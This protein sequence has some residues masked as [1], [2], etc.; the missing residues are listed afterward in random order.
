MRIP[1]SWIPPMSKRIVDSLISEE[2]II[3]ELDRA[4]LTNAVEALIT[5]E[6]SVEDRV[7][8]EVREV[9]KQYESEIDKGRL[10]YRKLFDLTKKKIVRERNI[11]L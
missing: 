5:E 9:L 8:E 3:T 1:K 6:L 2:L 11:I 4:Q 10:D 7:N